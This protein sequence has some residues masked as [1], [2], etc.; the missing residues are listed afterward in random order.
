MRTVSLRNLQGRAGRHHTLRESLA[1][2]T[3]TLVF[4]RLKIRKSNQQAHLDTVT[5]TLRH[6]YATVA[7]RFP[8]L[9]GGI[10]G[11]RFARVRKQGL[12]QLTDT[13]QGRGPG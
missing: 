11:S 5:S 13:P 8:T 9:A 7:P 10:V 2:Y 12:V 3:S 4:A 1:A 6:H